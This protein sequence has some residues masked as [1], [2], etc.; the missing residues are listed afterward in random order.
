MK[1][2]NTDKT[3][4]ALDCVLGTL[5]VT[6]ATRAGITNAHCLNCP[7]C[8]KWTFPSVCPSSLLLL[9]LGSKTKK[10]TGDYYSLY[11]L[12]VCIDAQESSPTEFTRVTYV[13]KNSTCLQG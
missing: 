11:S 4:A 8:S 5:W 3:L 12:S 9:C 6:S 10:G 13:C 7:K 2:Y 1:Y